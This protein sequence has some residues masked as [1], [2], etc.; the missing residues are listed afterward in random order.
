MIGGASQLRGLDS[1][2]STETNLTARL[3]DNPETAVVLGTGKTLDSIEI[4]ARY[5]G[6][7]H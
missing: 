6:V 5:E 4:L 1:L 7:R 3:S 2:I